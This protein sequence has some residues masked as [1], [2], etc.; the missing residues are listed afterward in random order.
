MQKKVF[1]HFL[2]GL[3]ILAFTNGAIAPIAQAAKKKKI[4]KYKE[5]EN[6]II[7][8]VPEKNIFEQKKRYKNIAKYLSKNLGLNVRIKVLPNYSKICDSFLSGEIDAGFFGSFSYV[9]TN[10]KIPL[11]PIARPLWRNGSSTYRGYLFTRK[12]SGITSLDEMKNKKL[13]LVHKAT[14]AG[15]IFQL[16]YFKKHGIQ[17]LEEYFSDIFFV[18]THES[19]AWT[20]YSGE[21]DVGGGK[22]HIFNTLAEENLDFK[23]Q[24]VI[25]AESPP[26]PSNGLAVRDNLDPILKK[27]LRRLLLNLNK[28]KEGKNILNKF[29]ALKFIETTNEDYSSLHKM[30]QDIGINLKDFPYKN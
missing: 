8:I 29:G 27:D 28:K 24:M 14:T 18:G 6:F 25:L 1:T 3:I 7:A 30:V 13:A 11:D 5:N 23:K 9:L 4:K 15:Y 19:S 16:D 20:V 17:N 21:A 22:N 12:D 10:A 26:V 2:I